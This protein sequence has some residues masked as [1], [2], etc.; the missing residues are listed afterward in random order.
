[1][2]ALGISKQTAAPIESPIRPTSHPHVSIVIPIY[3]ERGF[4]RASLTS[5]VTQLNHHGISHDILLV[6]QFSDDATIAESRSVADGFPTVRHELLAKPNFGLAM[7]HGMLMAKGDI[8]VNF[9]IDYW[10]VTFVRMCLATM[11]Q[12]DIDIVIGSKNAR[13]SVDG[14][15]FSRRLISNA[16]RLVLQ[17]FF[18]LRV[19]DTHGIKAW[20]RS[21]RLI[22]L[23]H[24]CR[25][26]EEIFDTELVIRGERAGLRLFELPV[27]VVEQRKP[28]SSIFARIPGAMM[29][30]V[31]LYLVL[32][33]ESSRRS[34]AR[35]GIAGRA[36]DTSV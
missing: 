1:M 23:I 27:T 10:D 14:R 33:R 2:N 17:S 34:A 18:G 11:I 4:L 8:I 35:G 16:F 15:A 19:S 28:R 29:H 24:E 21:P 22:E 12:F 5:L 9:D 6:E 3:R 25:F 31:Q 30:L 7:R 26:N 20:H 32:R 36:A 13:L